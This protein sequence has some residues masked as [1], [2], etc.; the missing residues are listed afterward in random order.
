MTTLVSRLTNENRPLLIM[1][2]A[3]VSNQFLFCMIKLL[4]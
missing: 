1:Q 3:K 4:C 2:S